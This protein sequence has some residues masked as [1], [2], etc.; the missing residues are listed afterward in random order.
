MSKLS[1]RYDPQKDIIEIEGT[2]YTGDFFRELGCNFPEMVGQVLRVDQKGD[3]VVALTRLYDVEDQ[4][5]NK[6]K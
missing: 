2:K 6:S 1:V 3:G 4:L 5:K